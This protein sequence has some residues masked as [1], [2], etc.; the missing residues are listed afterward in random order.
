MFMQQQWHDTMAMCWW[1]VDNKIIAQPKRTTEGETKMGKW[2]PVNVMFST[3]ETN[4]QDTVKSLVKIQSE[5]LSLCISCYHYAPLLIILC[6]LALL[7]FSPDSFA[8]PT[9]TPPSPPSRNWP[10][11]IKPFNLKLQQHEASLLFTSARLRGSLLY[12][13]SF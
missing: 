13:G 12:K 9:S 1:Y 3:E 6:A 4:W 5:R 10:S 8:Q 2:C 11:S 7:S